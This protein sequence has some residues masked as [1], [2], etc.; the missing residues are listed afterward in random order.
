VTALARLFALAGLV[1]L[2]TRI[3]VPILPAISASLAV[4]PG[5]VGYAVTAYTFGTAALGRLVDGQSGR[6]GASGP[7]RAYWSRRVKKFFTLWP[8]LLAPSL[9]FSQ[10]LLALG[11]AALPASSSF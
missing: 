1:S 10:A 9:T 4:G 8:K 6:I 2:D 11:S 5:E 7:R 3:M